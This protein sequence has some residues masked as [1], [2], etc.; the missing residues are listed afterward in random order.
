MDWDKTCDLKQASTKPFRER[1]R[2]ES[3]AERRRR[4][5]KSG[6]SVGGGEECTREVVVG[7]CLSYCLVSRS[8][9]REGCR[10]GKSV[11]KGGGILTPQ[12][13]MCM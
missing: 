8:E 7:F 4:G 2:R 5:D 10:V 1:E 12:V 3:P 6:K 13:V 11:M 9:D